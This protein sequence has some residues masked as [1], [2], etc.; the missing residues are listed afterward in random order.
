MVVTIQ[1]NVVCT[2]EDAFHLMK[3]ARKE[4]DDTKALE[5]RDL[6][7][8]SGPTEALQ[9][10]VRTAIAQKLLHCGGVALHTIGHQI[11]SSDMPLEP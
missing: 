9:L 1:A 6:F 5:D 3:I 2:I 7:Y 8:P 10:L 4:V 11:T